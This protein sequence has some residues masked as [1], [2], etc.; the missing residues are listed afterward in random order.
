MNDKAGAARPAELDATVE[1]IAERYGVTTTIVRQ[2]LALERLAPETRDALV[3]LVGK[4]TAWIS[5]LTDQVGILIL[6]N[7]DLLGR[8]AE[9]QVRV[10]RL[11]AKETKLA[12][13]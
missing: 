1:A 3:A 6:Q 9:L 2:R 7:A 12:P 4:Q 10:E 5:E 13:H 11:E 8:T